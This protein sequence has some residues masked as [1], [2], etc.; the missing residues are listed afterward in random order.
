MLNTVLNQPKNI[1]LLQNFLQQVFYIVQKR[2]FS[3]GVHLEEHRLTASCGDGRQPNR[4]VRILEH[5]QCQ[6][7]AV[8]S[9]HAVPFKY[10]DTAPGIALFEITAC[11]QIGRPT[12][13][14]DFLFQLPKQLVKVFVSDGLFKD[15]HNGSSVLT[16]KIQSLIFDTSRATGKLRR[17]RLKRG[18]LS[19]LIIAYLLEEQNT[20]CTPPAGGKD[21]SSGNSS[22]ANSASI[23]NFSLLITP[24]DSSRRTVSSG[25]R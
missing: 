14:R 2:F 20:L 10:T 15:C 7:Q 11:F 4:T 9:H 3:E 17:N 6:T 21:Q 8:A 19:N 5:G 1:L 12:A 23:S 13:V 25:I 22:S 24:S 16:I 18:I